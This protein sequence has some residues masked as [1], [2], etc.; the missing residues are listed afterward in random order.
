M[1]RVKEVQELLN[2]LEEIND[3]RHDFI[4]DIFEIFKIDKKFGCIDPEIYQKTVPMVFQFLHPKDQCKIHA[5]KYSH[6]PL[7]H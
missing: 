3:N 1:I 5:R 4:H 6:S 7:R 2:Q